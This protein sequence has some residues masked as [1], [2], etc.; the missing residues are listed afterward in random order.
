MSLTNGERLNRQSWT[1]LPMG[2]NII[3]AIEAMAL[4]EGQPII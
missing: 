1:E 3:A 2:N 4:S